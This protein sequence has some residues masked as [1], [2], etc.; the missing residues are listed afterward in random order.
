MTKENN[1]LNFDTYRIPEIIFI[2]LSFLS[3][4]QK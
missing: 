4:I 2:V 3:V 1:N